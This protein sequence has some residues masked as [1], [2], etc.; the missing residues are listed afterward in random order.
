MESI[1]KELKEKFQPKKELSE[2][3]S[4]SYK[5]L[6]LDNKSHNTKHCSTHLSFSGSKLKHA[7]FCRDRLCPMCAWRKSLKISG[8]MVQIVNQIQDKYNFIFLTLTVPNCSGSD[9]PKTLDRLQNAW[10]KLRKRKRFDIAVKGYFKALEVTHNLNK[11]SKS[12]NTYHP[13]Y[14]CIL[15]V[16]KDYFTSDDFIS[17]KEFLSIWRECYGDNS[18]N[19]VNV[20]KCYDRKTS[21]G[22]GKSLA[23]AVAE[24]AKYSV[25]ATSYLVGKNGK[26][27]SDTVIDSSVD[28]LSSALSH[29]RLFEMRGIFYDIHKLLNLDD[30]EDGDLV[31]TD[32]QE[33]PEQSETVEK[34]YYYYSFKQKKYILYKVEEIKTVDI[35]IEF[36]EEDELYKLL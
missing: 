17:Q 26:P 12:Y 10:S 28:V 14:H 30:A 8:Q 1:E 13:H 21:K 20:K 33:E 9:L 36:D 25:K 24:V 4:K 16:S 34:R 11:K 19:Q 29:R 27:Y 35:V 5:R 15:A 7:D 18:I 2:I 3:L 6:G 31:V 22:R 32:S 23:S